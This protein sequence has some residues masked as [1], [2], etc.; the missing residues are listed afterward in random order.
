MSKDPI[1]DHNRY[2]KFLE[3]VPLTKFREELKDVKWVEQDLPK[4]MLPLESIFRHYWFERRLLDFD[5]WFE[6]FWEELNTKPESKEA[7]KQFKKYFFDKDG[8]G[9][10]K[11]GFRARMYRTW[12]S[13]LTQLDFCYLF[14]S[15]CNRDNK[16]LELVCNAE[17]DAKG[18]DTMVNNIGFQIVKISQRK[19]A[20]TVRNKKNVITISYAV[21]NIEEFQ[22]RLTSPRVKDKTGYQKALNSFN[23]Y[24]IRLNNGFI[25]FKEDYF[26]P[27]VDNIDNSEKIRELVNKI[28]LELAGEG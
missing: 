21:F 26:K 15:I 4:G 8:N 23:K 27:I 16:K 19:E 9:W 3:S 28:S 14:E 22:Q 7:L 24:F 5:K 6:D 20:R 11:K 2:H 12:V 17:L 13:V 18:I 1:R 25:V 10:F